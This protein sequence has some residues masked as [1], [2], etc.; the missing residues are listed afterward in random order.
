[1]G[2]P[3]DEKGQAN[4]DY[5]KSVSQDISTVLQVK[6]DYCVVCV[7]ST[8]PPGTTD[9]IVLPLLEK[10]GK[11]T[12]IDFGLCMSPEFLAEGKALQDFLNPSRIVIGEYDTRSGNR[13]AELFR[14]FFSPVIHTDMRTAEMIKLASNAFLATKISFMG[15][16]GNICKQLAI[17]VYEV[18]R[19]MGFD[20]RIGSKY[21][22]AG[23]GFGGSCLPKDVKG[24]IY[25]SGELDYDSRLLKAVLELNEQ[26]PHRLIALLKKHLELK[27]ASIGVL[28]LS[29]K[30]DTD[31]IRE[32]PSIE[33]VKQLIYEGAHVK[34]YDPLAM[35]NFRKLFPRISYVDKNEVIKCNVLIIL[36]EWAEFK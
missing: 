31:D 26:Q 12:G 9:E 14:S 21:L 5:V 1:V 19:G 25:K 8:V 32:S 2:T 15:E 30:P 18:A 11:K 24:L 22:R 29:F 23:V 10:S 36:T 13:L 4:L 33:V 35:E 7:K 17:D 6:D 20:E 3:S 34:A 16:I 27:D 28:G